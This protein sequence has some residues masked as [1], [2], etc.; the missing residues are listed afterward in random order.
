[1]D[2]QEEPV[3]RHVLDAQKFRTDAACCEFDESSICPNAMVAVNQEVTGL[4]L[5]EA[6]NGRAF[7]PGLAGVA[8]FTFAEDL[9]FANH[10]E[11]FVAE[12]KTFA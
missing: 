9:F 6:V 1:M 11:P 4:E 12:F 10:H 2:G 7:L 3:S 5:G 8:F